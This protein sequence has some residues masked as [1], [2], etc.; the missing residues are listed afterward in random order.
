MR[1]LVISDTH[2]PV[3]EKKLPPII[4]EEAKKSN[5]CLHAGD[6]ID[7]ETFEQ[8]SKLVKVYAVCGNM[9]QD[10]VRKKLP[11]KEIVTLDDITIGL[12][13]GQGAPATI[14]DYINKEFAADLERIDII[15]YGHTHCPS[16]KE[17]NDKIYFNPGSPTD[18]VFA[19]YC[20]YGILEINGRDIKRRLVKIE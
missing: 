7:Y 8:L 4:E 5:C 6:M 19:P 11:A 16:D 17:I 20:S 3:T 13:H 18:R 9:D 10:Q 15:V 1:I 12:I 2:I 14:I